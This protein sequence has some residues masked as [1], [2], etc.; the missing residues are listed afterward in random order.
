MLEGSPNATSAIA[1][2]V[3][4]AS[5]AQLHRFAADPILGYCCWLV[6]RIASASWADDFAGELESVGLRVAPDTSVLSLIGQVADRVEHEMLATGPTTHLGEL[7]ALAIRRTLMDTVAEHTPSLFGSTLDDARFALRQY[8][9]GPQFGRL[10]RRFFGDL[11]G[12]TLRAAV[13]R[14]LP[15][16][17]GPGERIGNAAQSAALSARLDSYAR[18]SAGLMEQFAEEWYA[19]RTFPSRR[20]ITRDEAQGFAA[21]AMDKLQTELKLASGL[22]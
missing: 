10:A 11:F 1:A 16:C 2:A 9:S 7:S 6:S 14:A 22:G 4:D 3:V 5:E 20:A 17:V 18:D 15:N 21:H 12:R 13:D 8:A 19:A